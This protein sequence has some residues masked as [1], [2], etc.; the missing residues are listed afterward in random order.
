MLLKRHFERLLLSP[1]DL[2]PL[3]DD[4]EVVGVFNPGAI[5]A[6]GEVILLVRVAERPREARS[7]YAALAALV[8][9]RGPRDRLACRRTSRG[10]RPAGRETKSRRP[11]AADIHLASARRAVRRWTIACTR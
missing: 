3:R 10:A 7:G 1:S 2:T 9:G 6:N 11:G 8:A 5:L 4:F